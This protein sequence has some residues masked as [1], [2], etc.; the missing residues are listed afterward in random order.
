MTPRS[1]FDFFPVARVTED[2]APVASRAMLTTSALVLISPP[3]SAIIAESSEQ[4]LR[5]AL[6]DRRARRLEREGDDLGH[7]PE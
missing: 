3:F 6:D 7:L 4:L 2:A 1:R 5:A